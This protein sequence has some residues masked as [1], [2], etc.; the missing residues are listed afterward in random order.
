MAA[1]PPPPNFVLVAVRACGVPD[2]P[3]YDG[4]GPAERITNE[5]FEDGF[6]TCKTITKEDLYDNFKSYSNLTLA[7]G[8]IVLKMRNN[9]FF[10]IF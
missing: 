9:I 10:I 5:V 3:L 4:E 8:K 6:A 7:N 1:L 2:L